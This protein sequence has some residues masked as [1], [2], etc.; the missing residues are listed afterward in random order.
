MM[1]DH[2]QKCCA[3]LCHFKLQHTTDNGAQLCPHQLNRYSLVRTE[4]NCPVDI[5][6]RMSGADFIFGPNLSIYRHLPFLIAYRRAENLQT[7][8]NGAPVS[9]TFSEVQMRLLSMM[10]S[11]RSMLGLCS[12]G[13][14]C[15]SFGELFVLASNHSAEK[16][17]NRPIYS[18]IR[19]SG[20]DFFLKETDM[21]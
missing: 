12:M 14:S 19:F 9:S 13:I 15:R 2:C 11:G 1:H 4:G 6:N 5:L 7:G 10:R 8:R 21:Y 18:H 16:S 3:M 17:V 20:I